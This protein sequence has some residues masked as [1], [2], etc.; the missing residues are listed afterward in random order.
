MRGL[1][2]LVLLA[3]AM[4]ILVFTPPAEDA[5][6]QASGCE[7]FNEQQLRA[8][9][10]AAN[11]QTSAYT[12]D[13]RSDII[14]TQL[15]PSLSN[16]SIG[17]NTFVHFEGNGYRINSN[18]GG[19]ALFVTQGNWLIANL[20]VTGGQ[21][22]ISGVGGTILLDSVTTHG[23]NADGVNL[24]GTGVFRSVNS[25]FANNGDDGLQVSGTFSAQVRQST[26]VDNAFGIF[27]DSTFGVDV[28]GSLLARSSSSNCAA[29]AGSG[30][31]INGSGTYTGSAVCPGNVASGLG[32]T[33]GASLSVSP[34]CNRNPACTPTFSL[35]P[36][37]PAIDAVADCSFEGEDQRGVPRSTQCDAGAYEAFDCSQNASVSNETD[38]GFAIGCFNN[39]AA[40]TVA[41][42]DIEQDITLTD[43]LPPVD[44]PTSG[45]QLTIDGAGHTLDGGGR[46][47]AIIRQSDGVLVLQNLELTNG[48][49]GVYSTGGIYVLEN[50]LSR[51]NTRFG[52]WVGGTAEATMI[53]T[54]FFANVEAIR[55]SNNA[56]LD[57]WGVT[58]ANHGNGIV[59]T[60]SG[61]VRLT[62]SL[63]ARN[64]NACGPNTN[65][66]RLQ[67]NV[68]NDATCGGASA[69]G[70]GLLLAAAPA[71]NGAT[72][73]P[74]TLA[75]LPGS[76]AVDAG[77]CAQLPTD[78]R[79]VIRAGASGGADKDQCD[80]GAFE[81]G[82][83]DVDD[84]GFG[85]P[86]GDMTDCDDTDPLI[87]PDATDIP[88]DGIDQD[89][90][91]GDE[92]LASVFCQGVEV[93]INMNAGAS[94]HGTSGPD[95]ILGTPGNDMID[96]GD[97]DDVICAG[98]GDDTVVGGDGDDKILG[99]GGRDV[100]R[101][102]P[103]VDLVDG[104][105]G[106]DRVLGGI[107][108]D[109]MYGRDGDDYLGGFGGADRIF[110]GNGNE[111]IFGGFG[112]DIID[113]GEGNDVISG[114]IGND[115]INGGPGNDTLNGDR[116]R[117]T[118]FGDEGNDL[119]NGGNSDDVLR[120][121]AGDDTVNG[122]RADDDLFGDSG[123][124]VCV[125]NKENARGDVAD[126]S[127]DQTFGIP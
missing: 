94:G 54:T 111:R 28:T 27:G 85:G 75:L 6:A 115:T 36:G 1:R 59:T 37:S 7:A 2:F 31:V 40:S 42:I 33:I 108:D 67:G 70:V 82:D 18:G 13:L 86:I 66:E 3:M 120:G 53:N 56:Q 104:G 125:G 96:S 4:S 14:L 63:I 78:A 72:L 107:G 52:A 23:N 15:L 95:V 64:G 114:L 30:G 113:G 57:T 32:T 29:S 61:V 106:N 73:R 69:P 50:V 99:E 22:G 92:P 47:G 80:A 110:G 89:C 21:N 41:M 58:I 124:D 102:G 65:L 55:V 126:A 101:G 123:V 5:Q 44:R 84:D 19:S 12:I 71:P 46:D 74:D 90:V 60:E 9:I 91:G 81:L 25:T 127:C 68:I 93:T 83:S 79:G 112:A 105:A 38:L 35:L 39:G 87:N 119:I 97:G 116:G 118:I 10:G 48:Q 77:N 34:I 11:D 26:F 122:G 76:A 49:D 17:A 121:G 98:D 62:G 45:G 16:T 100:L 117:D 43:S 103:G 51:D 24:N 88:G 109:T 8:C 20:E